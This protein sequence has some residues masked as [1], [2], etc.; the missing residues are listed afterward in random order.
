MSTS[1]VNAPDYIWVLGLDD[2]DIDTET[3]GW[4]FV[5]KRTERAAVPTD[6]LA[7]QMH[8]FVAAVQKIVGGVP[9]AVGGFTVESVEVSAEVSATGK[10]SFLGSGGELSGTGGITF[11]LTRKP[12]AAGTEAR[13]PN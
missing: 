1:P 5:P 10:V 13:S 3:R 11:T 8:D 6:R 12:A 7:D 4:R 9:A 2:E